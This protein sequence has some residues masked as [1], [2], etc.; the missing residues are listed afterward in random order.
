MTPKTTFTSLLVPLLVPLLAWLPALSAQAAEIDTAQ[1]S[2]T[3]RILAA[4]EFAGRAPG[5]PGEEKT[6]NYLVERFTALGLEPGGANGSWTQAVPLVHTRLQ[7]PITLELAIGA[8]RQPLVQGQD[9]EVSTV[10]P[11][12][13]IAINAAPVVFVGF[14]VHA[15]E[16]QWDD[17]GDIDLTGKVALFLVNDPDFAA[18]PE[19]AVAGRF[20]NRRMT[21]YGRWTYKFE[22]A[23]RRG[24]VAALIVHHD[25]GAGDGW[26]VAA[27]SPGE[28]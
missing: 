27:S 11:L 13:H 14:G 19:E 1:L 26:N 7:P 3:V 9:V 23:A 18:G 22:E 5:G 10:R 2:A 15:P 16:R 17:F 24:A 20:G 12:Q 6:I 21:Y 28:N 8:L 4:N 25:N